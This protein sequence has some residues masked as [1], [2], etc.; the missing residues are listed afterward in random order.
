[1]QL[2]RN[3]ND[4]DVLPGDTLRDTQGQTYLFKEI[5]SGKVYVANDENLIAKRPEELGCYL[6]TSTLSDLGK[7]K[8][9]LR[10]FWEE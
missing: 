8:Q 6:L 7:S 4:K 1:M 2:R 10:S 5:S 9:K 3:L